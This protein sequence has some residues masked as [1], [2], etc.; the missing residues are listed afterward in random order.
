VCESRTKAIQKNKIIL[1]L[2]AVVFCKNEHNAA[3]NMEKVV[4]ACLYSSSLYCRHEL[5]LIEILLLFKWM[6]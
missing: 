1:N 3:S 4:H 6:I 5:R 2:L